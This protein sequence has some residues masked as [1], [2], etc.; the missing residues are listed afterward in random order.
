[1][2]RSTMTEEKALENF[3]KKVDCSQCVF[4]Q[5]AAQLGLEEKEAMDIANLFGGGMMHG[6]VCGAVTGALMAIGLKCGQLDGTYYENKEAA[7]QMKNEFEEAFTDEFGTLICSEM[8]GKKIPE[9]FP[10]A[11]QEGK[12]KTV[13]APAVTLACNILEELFNRQ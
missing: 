5:F 6:N 8:L 13:C 7:I 4:G 1:M 11:V 12:T 2:Y 10:Q 9:E 3:S